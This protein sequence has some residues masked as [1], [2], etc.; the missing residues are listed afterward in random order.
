EPNWVR[1]LST[2]PGAGDLSLVRIG[3]VRENGSV[4]HMVLHVA[5]TEAG[6]R[7]VDWSTW[8]LPQLQSLRIRPKAPVGPKLRV[9]DHTGPEDAMAAMLAAIQQGDPATVFATFDALDPALQ[10]HPTVRTLRLQAWPSDNPEWP[11]AYRLL[12]A[13][14]PRNPFV[15]LYG[16]F[17]EIEANRLAEAVELLDRLLV[18]AGRDAYLMCLKAGLLA[19]VGKEEEADSVTAEALAAEPG[20]EQIIDC[21]VR[22]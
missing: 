21:R 17:A 2:T 10:R 14:H 7:V 15:L 9:P 1:H 16:V 8:T 19:E 22:S 4:E 5:R 3:L 12:L 18:V 20:I 13:D 6:V 11:P